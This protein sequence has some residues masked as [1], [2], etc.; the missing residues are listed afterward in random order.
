MVES[1][2]HDY[3]EP[4][5]SDE[6]S[7]NSLKKEQATRWNS[8]LTSIES[9]LEN[10]VV[11]RE[12]LSSEQF[13]SPHLILTNDEMS[14]LKKLAEFLK[15]FRCQ[16]DALQGDRYPTISLISP[17]IQVLLRQCDV[18]APQESSCLPSDW[19]IS[20]TQLKINVKTA[21]LQRFPSDLDGSV[22]NPIFRLATTLDIRF[23]T[24]KS[25]FKTVVDF[26]DAIN[27]YDRKLGPLPPSEPSA[28]SSTP[29]ENSMRTANTTAPSSSSKK[30]KIS[31]LYGIVLDAEPATNGT[32]EE[33]LKAEM[34]N[35]LAIPRLSAD[36]MDE[37]DILSWWKGRQYDFPLLAIYARQ[38]LGIV[39]TSASSERV[40]STG[41]NV[42]TQQRQRLD[43]Q[44]VDKL[45][46]LSANSAAKKQ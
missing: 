26:V 21:M 11:I 13:D 4:I 36:E 31:A 7:Q 22:L 6:I 35:F 32:R 12:L 3:S 25:S 29:T 39:A 27:Y 43:P 33:L 16:T 18:E 17:A 2:D 44:N 5:S 40:F 28:A 14:L 37:L 10:R 42:V 9:V 19:E 30:I 24:N 34:Q 8:T 41:G 38:I 23:K 20:M 1:E 46:F 45:I 15:P